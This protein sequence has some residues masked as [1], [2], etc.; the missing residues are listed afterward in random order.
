MDQ[1]SRKIH[2]SAIE[3]RQMPLL[4]RSS[5]KVA[6]RISSQTNPD[7]RDLKELRKLSATPQDLDGFSH[8]AKSTD[9]EQ[10]DKDMQSEQ[11]SRAD[12]ADPCVV[13]KVVTKDDV[14]SIPVHKDARSEPNLEAVQEL[15]VEAFSK[16]PSEMPAPAEKK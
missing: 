10:L 7:Q 6:P 15:V 13:S 11:I 9:N 5:D 8:Q 12:R 2:F 14:K 4:R 16:V 3:N 1:C